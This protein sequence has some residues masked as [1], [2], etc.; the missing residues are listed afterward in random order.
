[1]V[2][3]YKVLKV[4]EESKDY[5]AEGRGYKSWYG[6]GGGVEGGVESRRGAVT[7]VTR[8]T[9]HHAPRLVDE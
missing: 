5:C 1:M 3:I 2:R 4:S 7:C 8:A 6:G 9:D